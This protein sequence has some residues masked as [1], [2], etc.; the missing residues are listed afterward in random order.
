MRFWASKSIFINYSSK[1]LIMMYNLNSLIFNF[2]RADECRIL[3][4]IYYYLLIIYVKK[5]QIAAVNKICHYSTM[6]RIISAEKRND[7]WITHRLN[8]MKPLAVYE[9][10][11]KAQIKEHTV[12]VEMNASDKTTFICWELSVKKIHQPTYHTR[13]NLHSLAFLLRY[14]A[15]YS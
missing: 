13:I 8:D 1:V 6:V 15:A 5:G 3:P 14:E 2:Y 12:L 9:T 7:H 11:Y 4:E 10:Y